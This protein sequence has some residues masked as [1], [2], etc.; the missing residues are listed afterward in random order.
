MNAKDSIVGNVYT[1]FSGDDF[2][3]T[4][5]LGSREIY[6][7]FLNTG[8]ETVTAN[9][10]I[11][12][13]LIRDRLK[14]SLYGI[15]ILGDVETHLEGVRLK[16]Y[17]LWKDMFYRCYSERFLNMRPTYKGCSV[18]ENFKYFSYF[19]DWCNK[20]VGFGNEGWHLDKDILVKGN[21]VY[22]EDTCCFVPKE[23]NVLL[24]KSNARRG[25]YPIGVSYRKDRNK[26]KAGINN[27]IGSCFIGYFNTPEE[28]FYAYKEVK[29]TKIKV[30]AEK[31]KGLID[32][33][34]YEA[35]MNYQVEI[36]D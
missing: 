4:S 15:G 7:K 33:R 20:Q 3:V 26:Y 18:S 35:L 17:Y 27:T 14:P 13:G 1:T 9:N 10:H 2:I 19:K 16:E 11:Q 31:W 25:E 29:E 5:Y 34:V 21:K 6:I 36:T 8:Y 30:V 23:I 12:S 32:Q 28:A 24:V 22:S